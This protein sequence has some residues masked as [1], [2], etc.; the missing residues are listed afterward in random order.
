MIYAQIAQKGDGNMLHSKSKI[1]HM[2]SSRFLPTID[3]PM[4]VSCPASIDA[5]LD[6][7]FHK[8]QRMNKF[9]RKEDQLEYWAAWQVEQ[10]DLMEASK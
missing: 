4:R 10:A 1:Q 6:F 2:K 3:E 9:L 5:M 8:S 7:L